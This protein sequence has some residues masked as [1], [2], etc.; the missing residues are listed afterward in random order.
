MLALGPEMLSGTEPVSQASGGLHIW[1][2]RCSVSLNLYHRH[3]VVST[4]GTRNSQWHW[5]HTTGIWWSPYFTPSPGRLSYQTPD[6]TAEYHTQQERDSR[7]TYHREGQGGLL[8]WIYSWTICRGLGE[9]EEEAR[10]C[11]ALH[12]SLQS[13]CR[14]TTVCS[15]FCRQLWAVFKCEIGWQRKRSYHLTSGS[16]EGGCSEKY[17]GASSTHAHAH[18]KFSRTISILQEI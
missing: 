3:L 8:P 2:Q 14:V 18:Y 6:Y 15:T 17:G 4:S 16:M 10:D 9:R 13:L 12:W 5:I 1:D 11:H 7:E